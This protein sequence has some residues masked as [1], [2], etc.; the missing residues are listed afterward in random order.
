M[1]TDESTDQQE[2]AGQADVMAR[3][4][5]SAES[6]FLEKGF[7]A[8][9]MDAIARRAGCSKKT[10]YKLVT[11][12]EDLFFKVL[13]RGKS[14]IMA[15]RV[16]ESLPPAEALADFVL[17]AARYIL[18]PHYVAIERMVLGEYN[19][20]PELMRLAQQRW[21][22]VTRFP[23]EVYLSALGE[24]GDFEPG[25]AN[26]A[27]RMLMGMAIGAF[28]HEIQVGMRRS[29]PD[30]EIVARVERSVEIFLRGIRRG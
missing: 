29:V 23:L 20:A 18:D 4:L 1:L 12:K 26:E 21:S 22:D 2:L 5:E 30:E 17:R 28:H 10:I 16:D 25:D 11:S 9:T 8:C 27:S 19:R 24:F 14:R 7:H 13:D 3:L 6:L 15:I